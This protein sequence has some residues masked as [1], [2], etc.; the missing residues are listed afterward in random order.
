MDDVP[1][2]TLIHR[3]T[4]TLVL[5]VMIAV[6]AFVVTRAVAHANQA[7]RLR[8]AQA[9][10]ARGQDSLGGVDAAS[11]VRQLRRAAALDPSSLPFRLELARA[12]AADAPAEARRVLLDSRAAAPQNAD[13]NLALGRLEAVHGDASATIGAYQA[14]LNNL[15][16]PDD[17][18]SRYQVRVELARYLLAQHQRS[19]ALSELLIVSTEIP[20]T[21]AA[22]AEL[23]GLFSEAAEPARALAQL[24]RARALDPS[25]QS[26]AL[27]SGRAAF[28]LG[29]DAMALRHLRAAPDLAPAR[30]LASTIT[31]ALANDPLLPR[32]SAA[33][34]ERRLRAGLAQARLR[35]E[36]CTAGSP[37][38]EGAPP[39]GLLEQLDRFDASLAP[40]RNRAPVVDVLDDG[41]ELIAGIEAQTVACGPP[42]ALDRALAL[43][44]RRHAGPS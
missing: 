41:V 19:R 6:A 31:L 8:D 30:E 1:S 15:W 9:W 23:G 28:A 40:Q 5:L 20:D 43:I 11:A 7:R 17:A 33:E 26:V 25:N 35:L 42:A 29:D 27:A 3:E 24:E 13:V 16:R 18:V 36:G 4:R 39:S 38:A 14:A 37:P 12:L 32:L 22:H 44:G 34:R 2:P 10:F 21:T